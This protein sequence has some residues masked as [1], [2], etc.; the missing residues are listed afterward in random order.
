M[1]Y[2]AFFS[3]KVEVD[4]TNYW[5]NDLLPVSMMQVDGGAKRIIDFRSTNDISLVSELEQARSSQNIILY[6]SATND[7]KDRKAAVDLMNI[8][9]SYRSMKTL[10]TVER[11]SGGKMIEGISLFAGKAVMKFPPANAF[12]NTLSVW[13]KLYE[14]QIFTGKVVNHGIPTYFDELSL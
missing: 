14:I 11:F 2:K 4:D 3:F 10:L 7:H 5:E 6:L 12:K 8:L 13:F 9:R 1:R